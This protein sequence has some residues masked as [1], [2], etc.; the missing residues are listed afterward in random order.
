MG[1][2]LNEFC[3]EDRGPLRV[4]WEA[5][6]KEIRSGRKAARL[7]LIDPYCHGGVLRSYSETAGTAGV[8]DRLE[9]DVLGTARQL[10]NIREELGALKSKLQVRVYR[11]APTMF[12]C[13]FK[14]VTFVQ[15]YYFW[16]AR[17]PETPFPVLQFE[18]RQ[19]AQVATCIHTELEQHFNFIWEHASIPLDQ[20]DDQPPIE[21][22]HYFLPQPT[23]GLEW[24]AHASGMEN[25][26]IDR[27]LAAQRMIE[28][29]QRSKRVWIQGITLGAFFNDSD[30]ANVLKKKIQK[31]TD[32]DDI[33]VM[34][35]DPD[36]EQARLRAYREFI[37]NSN[38]V[39]TFDD[40]CNDK[41]E[42]STLKKD[43]RRTLEKIRMIVPTDAN[44]NVMKKYS[45]APHMFVVICDNAAFVEQ[46]TYGKVAESDTYK[47]VILGSDM[48][49]I[50]Y[51]KR[52]DPIYAQVLKNLRN[53]KREI[54]GHLRPQPYLLLENHFKWAWKQAI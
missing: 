11:L 24:G 47:E 16:K 32:G 7:L 6:V 29:I 12:V 27:H 23:R 51:E 34:L 26:F 3:R 38:N 25:V 40:F 31:R 54:S 9:G 22:T 4:A 46:Y 50:E 45:T 5:F 35:L 36:C 33:R 49:L 52:I 15:Y 42:D 48:P 10:R 19:D 21:P 41:Y 44:P 18:K 13:H 43:L 8:Q 53:E 28:E 2:S 39:I 30:I 20:L 37:L 17:L 14:S 1:I